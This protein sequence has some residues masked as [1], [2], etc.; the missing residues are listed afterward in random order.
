[1]GIKKHEITLGLGEEYDYI[2]HY[3]NK[4]LPKRKERAQ[5]A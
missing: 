2:D 3:Q 4:I 1:M 5:E